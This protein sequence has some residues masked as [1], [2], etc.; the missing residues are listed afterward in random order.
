M[1]HRECLSPN[2]SWSITST[3]AFTIPTWYLVSLVVNSVLVIT[4]NI[5]NVLVLHKM[6][7][8]SKTTKMLL[9]S[10]SVVDLISGILMAV[11]SVPSAILGKWVFGDI[12]CICTGVLYP[13]TLCLSLVFLTLI[14][15]DRYISI[16]KPLHYRLLVTR[17]RALVC[18]VLSSI[19]VLICVYI[20]GSIEKPFDNV[21]FLPE[22]SS[23]VIDF[24]H[25]C[26]ARLTV[27]LFSI[28]LFQPF[29]TLTVVYLRI[30]CI[31]HKSAREMAKFDPNR[32]QHPG[33]RQHLF[34]INSKA[35]KMTLVITGLFIL[36]WSPYV[37]TKVYSA[38]T[39][40]N[41]NPGITYFVVAY[42][43]I[44]NSWWNFVIYS[45][46]N[47]RFRQTFVLYYVPKKLH[48]VF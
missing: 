28:F 27:I 10:L 32:L 19:A 36:S 4:G 13:I 17:K 40:V 20:F 45:A 11:F 44:L 38:A 24:L 16:V 35:T 26:I 9:V 18:I 46:M 7:T 14:C 37:S 41:L 22:L 34:R 47:Q 42:L 39:G 25:P 2:T 12:L 3:A 43:A 23:C 31:V 6:K 8:L 33:G 30:L 21:R 1:S 5:I 29:V 48:N 15:I